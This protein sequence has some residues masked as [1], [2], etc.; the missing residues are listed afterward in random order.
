[1]PELES[2]NVANVIIGIFKVKI[3]QKIQILDRCKG[4][5]TET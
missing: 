3:G 1:M 2:K 5:T 4:I